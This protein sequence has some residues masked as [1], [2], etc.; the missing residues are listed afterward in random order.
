VHVLNQNGQYPNSLSVRLDRNPDAWIFKGSEVVELRARVC[1]RCGYAELYA[2]NAAALWSAYE[3]QVRTEPGPDG[4]TRRRANEP[5]P[6][7][8]AVWI[9]GQQQTKTQMRAVQEL[10]LKHRIPAQAAYQ[11]AVK[12]RRGV[13]VYVPVRDAEA[14]AALV[15]ALQGLGVSAEVVESHTAEGEG[16][17]PPS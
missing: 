9:D 5:Q 14:G 8:W 10:L 7:P 17:G 15:N 2:T 4:I 6:P 16:A 1:G 13:R 11:A 3:E 12:F